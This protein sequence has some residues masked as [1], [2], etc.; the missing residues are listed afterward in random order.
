MSNTQTLATIF[1]AP[2]PLAF[3]DGRTFQARPL[4]LGVLSQAMERM[5]EERIRWLE[6]PSVAD[7]IRDTRGQ[8]ASS[9]AV[10]LKTLADLRT[11]ASQATLDDVLHWMISNVGN[12]VA[13]VRASILTDEKPT[14]E[15]V[16]AA[17]MH[18]IRTGNTFI[19]RWMEISFA[20]NPTQPPQELSSGE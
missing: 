17:L 12:M 2:I 18:D 13:C 1:G 6:L 4:G 3:P 20:E 14:D 10:V 19:D 16:F 11:Q 7:V 9:I 5:I 15:E 8:D